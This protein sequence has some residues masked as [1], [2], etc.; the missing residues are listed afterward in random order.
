VLAL[1]LLRANELVSGDRLIQ[2][3][4]DGNPPETASNVVQGYVSRLRKALP[5]GADVLVTRAPGYVL[6]VAPGRL[7]LER[8]Q[9]LATE[10]Q[11]LLE[12]GAAE[13]ASERLREA[14][15]LWRGSPLAD[16]E[17]EP[18]ARDVVAHLEE[19]RLDVLEGR[20]E[21]DLASGRPA[22]I[23]PELQLLVAEQP[24]R[25]RLRA[26]LMLAL[27]RSGRQ[28]EA[29]DAYNDARHLLSEQLG[30]EPAPALR[31]LQRAILEHDATLLGAPAEGAPTPDA[32][33]ERA[34]V[35]C[36]RELE[37]LHVLTPLADA[38]AS[39]EP[40][41]ELILVQIAPALDLAAATAG[42][43]AAR[44][45]LAGPAADA[46]VAVF[47]STDP[48]RDTARFAGR[49]AADLL[50]ADVGPGVLDD[51]VVDLLPAAPCDI[52]L[53]VRGGGAPR[54]GQILVPF[55]GGDHDWAALELGAWLSRATQQTLRL[56]GATGERPDEPDA[57]RL[58]ADAS[59]V[60]QRATG[61]VALPL[62]SKSGHGGIAAAAAGAGA[63]L[64][65][66]SERWRDEGLG[67]A[68]AA[69]CAEPPCPVVVTCRGA[70]SGLLS[71]PSRASRFPWSVTRPRATL[72]P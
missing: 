1:L 26:N 13:S 23:V 21:A 50:L 36:P 52:A 49:H 53:L 11:A 54:P 7:D 46:R 19:L 40:R 35:V 71:P 22:E 9:A 18:F 65:G 4:W 57:S 64:L 25:E 8:F 59:L 70:R 27:Y 32:V 6:S 24:L 69:L 37:S 43:A 29:L 58:L 55:G 15:G 16:L 38:L 66:L 10:G 31:R 72:R 3:L 42:L 5:G 33:A 41:H 51:D 62:L 30:L 56:L 48:G 63:L 47:A 44:E 39:A 34:V 17:H 68:R 61:I 2:D 60:L 45:S 67:R 28:A 12:A 20:I 14:L